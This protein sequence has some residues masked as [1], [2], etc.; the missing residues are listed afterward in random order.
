MAELP[1]NLFGD[2]PLTAQDLLDIKYY[3]EFDRRV[4]EL[5][6]DEAEAA[7]VAIFLDPGV[8][9][10]PTRYKDIS[11]WY[12]YCDFLIDLRKK[13]LSFEEIDAKRH[14]F[15]PKH[16]LVDFDEWYSRGC[17]IVT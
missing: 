11:D 4:E 7:D 1:E 6:P 12:A 10:P 9:C 5:W 16:G 2:V 8:D 14:E 17:H 3:D 13:G 15:A